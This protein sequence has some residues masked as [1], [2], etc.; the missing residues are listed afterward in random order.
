MYRKCMESIAENI[1]ADQY[2]GLNGWKSL[3][4]SGH[5]S[6]NS[7][8][9]LPCL[10]SLMF[11]TRSISVP[12]EQNNSNK[13]IP[14]LKMSACKREKTHGWISNLVV[15]T[16]RTLG[17]LEIRAEIDGCDLLAI[18]KHRLNHSH[19]RS[20]WTISNTGLTASTLPCY[21][22]CCSSVALATHRYKYPPQLWARLYP[23][24][25]QIRKI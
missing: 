21:H 2:K 18:R 12:N 11:F 14:K 17:C 6:E 13:M 4:S 5:F 23:K 10:R 8:D 22:K 15:Y 1:H 9:N 25:L 24:N 19:I 16:V 20:N 7:W 3:T